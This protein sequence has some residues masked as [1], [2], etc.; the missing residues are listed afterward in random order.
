[1]QNPGAAGTRQPG[2]IRNLDTQEYNE[3]PASEQAPATPYEGALAAIARGIPVFPCEPGT[4]I[5]AVDGWQQKATTDSD[6]V[7]AMWHCPVTGWELPRNPAT[8]T[9]NGRQVVD[10]DTK[11]GRNGPANFAALADLYDWNPKTYRVR[12][13]SGGEHLWFRVNGKYR[14]SEGRLGTGIDTRGDGGLVLLPGA[15]NAEGAPY[16]L[17]D[18][19]PEAPLHPKIV[20]RL[21]PYEPPVAREPE[22]ATDQDDAYAV[23]R[24]IEYLQTVAPIPTEG[25]TGN[26]I[27]YSVAAELKKYAISR[28]TA[29]ALMDEHWNQLELLRLL[30][31]LAA[32]RTDSDSALTLKEIVQAALANDLVEAASEKDATDSM[33]RRL[34]KLH[35]A[36]L[37]RDM[38]SGWRP[39]APTEAGTGVFS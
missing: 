9:G 8:P 28:E 20:A 18:D 10:L 1:M 2:R 34:K 15:L 6:E 35:G 38:G 33:R 39:V 12:S 30:R 4:K 19:A 26:S 22:T 31:S 27:G 24:A 11:K 29:V 17:L 36:G 37:L 23:S 14:N 25:G 16:V 13:P 5:P 32:E 3:K 21:K 7:Y